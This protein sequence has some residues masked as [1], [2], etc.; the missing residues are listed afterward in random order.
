M[1]LINAVTNAP[2][3]KSFGRSSHRAL[4]KQFTAARSV[5]TKKCRWSSPIFTTTSRWRINPRWH[6]S[7][8]C[9]EC[10][11]SNFWSNVIPRASGMPWSCEL[12][13]DPGDFGSQICSRYP[14]NKPL[15]HY[16]PRKHPTTPSIE[17]LI[18]TFVEPLKTKPNFQ[19]EKSALLPYT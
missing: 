12:L 8:S 11:Q 14:I 9:S 10:L 3:W 18:N 5:L 15:S 17:P 16:L 13:T 4:L 19:V 6:D 7:I 1:S 2:N